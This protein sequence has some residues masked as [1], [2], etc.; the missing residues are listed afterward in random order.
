M[1]VVTSVTDPLEVPTVAMVKAPVLGVVFPIA[2]GVAQVW[3]TA[4]SQF[5]SRFD[6]IV[7]DVTTRGAV[8]VETVEVNWLPVTVPPA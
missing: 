1:T 2:G 6:T 8:P 4:P 3:F 5:A 7:V